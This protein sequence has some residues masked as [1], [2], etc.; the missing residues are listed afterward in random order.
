MYALTS[1]FLTTSKNS[2]IHVFGEQG[3]RN[4]ESARLLQKM[5][6]VRFRPGAICGLSL[7]LVLALLRGFFPG[8]PVF[9]LPQKPT[10]QIPIRTG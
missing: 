6:R 5:A 1:P 9:F 8:S 7:L 2:R 3:L 10:L 4:G